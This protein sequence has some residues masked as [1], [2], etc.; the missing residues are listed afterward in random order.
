MAS[1]QGR[2][3]GPPDRL[4]PYVPRIAAEWDLE[5]PG[6]THRRV[7][8]TL[9]FVDISGFTALSEKLA[10]KGRIGAEQLTEILDSAFG[11]M[12]GLAYERGGSLLKF[13]GDALL[14][15]FE[16]SDH[17]IQAC[18]AAVEMRTA[19]A[20]SPG[21]LRMSIGIHTGAID[22]F[23]VGRLH[24]ELIVTGP[25]ASDTARLESAASAGE[26]LV[27]PAV[28]E[29]L[30][31]G[32][33]DSPK[34]P[35]YLL[36]W[37]SPRLQGH[38]IVARRPVPPEAVELSLEAGLRSHLSQAKVESEHRFAISGFVSFSG[39]DSLVEQDA[40]GVAASALDALISGI[41]EAAATEEVTFL[42]SDIYV[43]GGKILL[44]TG[45][46]HTRE[47]DE[48]RMLRTLRNIA[49]IETPLAVRI[50]VNRG[51]VFS[52]D[53]GT[54]FRRTYTI[55]GDAVNLAARLMAAAPP[56]QI[57]ADP[58]VLSRSRTLFETT[59]VPPFTVKGKTTPVRA[60]ALGPE[61][62]TRLVGPG[63]GLP[64]TGRVKEI[65]TIRTALTRLDGGDGGVITVTGEAGIGK[66]RL[67]REA[68]GDDRVSL[69]VRGEPNAAVNPYRPLRDPL[70]R[71][72][73][74]ER[75]D[76]AEMRRKLS[77]RVEQ[78]APDLAWALPLIGDA[79]HIAVPETEETKQIEPQFRPGRTADAV[80]RLL[81]ALFPDGMVA[82]AEDA[83]WFDAGSARIFTKIATAS[84]ER[85]WLMVATRRP[86]GQGFDSDLGVRIDLGALTD[87]ESKRAVI[88]ATASTPLRPDQIDAIVRRAGG[89]PMFLEEIVKDVTESGGLDDLPDSLDAI[90]GAE[91]DALPPLPRRL[92]RYSSVLGQSFRP[93]VLAQL[94]AEEDLE[95]DAATRRALARFIEIDDEGRY[96]FR[97]AVARDVAYNKLSYRKRRQLHARAGVVIEELADKDT[98]PV[99]G[100][101]ALHYAEAGNHEKAWRYGVIAGDRAK[102]AYANV[103]AAVH[104]R[105]A[106]A[107]ARFLEGAMDRS[108]VGV[109]ESLGDVLE[110]AGR[111]EE[112]LS[113][114]SRAMAATDDAVV[115]AR[116]MMKR[117][118][119]HVRVGSYLPAV[120]QTTLGIRMVQGEGGVAAA[121]TLSQLTALASG[122]RLQEGRPALALALAEHAKELARESGDRDALARVYTVMD[123]ALE[124]LGRAGEA[125]YASAARALYEELEDTPGVAT[126]DN[127]VGVRAYD[128]GRW[129]EAIT[130]YVSAQDAFSRAGNLSQAALCGANIG[131]VLVSQGR[132]DEAEPILREAV[133]TLRAASF[134]D[135]AIFAEIQLARAEVAR[136]N[137]ASA[138]ETLKA[139][140]AEAASLGQRDIALEASI[141]LADAMV[142]NGLPSEAI[143]VL[144]GAEDDAGE[145]AAL[146]EAGLLR[147]RA[148]AALA[149][150]RPDEARSLATKGIAVA[151]DQG[152]VYEEALLLRT[153]A[154]TGTE[155][156]LNDLEEANRLLQNL[157]VVG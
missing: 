75:A 54:S 59:P 18:S 157:G 33:A 88:D 103:E 34:A 69:I 32:S 139:L 97:H 19:L 39:F 118:R 71:A 15:M 9:C 125:V 27:G 41:Q 151:R 129:D 44:T 91:I 123:G 108:V 82:V 10:Q 11:A 60:F 77:V 1:A 122:I 45:V 38:G 6:A 146:Y 95:V 116:I 74:I 12:L 109:A 117:A 4:A 61:T 94:I 149:S 40:A 111:F 120:R 155:D 105:G 106:L 72:L 24:R 16:G 7:D 138:V 132:W 100:P 50:G 3:E 79:V 98:D 76:Q 62:G 136:G 92:L 154:E 46:P 73:G 147:V 36:K 2:S 31:K 140:R 66:S 64:F 110:Q 17:P 112:A 101:L 56:G 65:A 130:A 49:D 113:A 127:N 58:G 102:A 14:L 47:D 99:A 21:K 119:V 30:P 115:K 5:A 84:S 68:V 96:R 150:D 141:H 13:G 93:V 156:T 142:E 148:R 20:R 81:A 43:D 133:R 87:V 143:Q 57:Y 25:V 67:V 80:L 35:G 63:R 145:E 53:V 135:L 107:Q 131:E 114:F 128:E 29:A 124:M 153:R 52:G 83:H 28:R 137:R 126:V 55:E 89:N 70:R 152:L 23:R 26:I 37:R 78:L 134:V 8:G 90:V 22:L 42:A 85:P 51:H 144:A 48:G 121:R 86:V 104:Y